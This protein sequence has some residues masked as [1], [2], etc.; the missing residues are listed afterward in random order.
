VTI[1]SPQSPKKKT[2][3]EIEGGKEP[4][5][6]ESQGASYKPEEIAFTL[7]LTDLGS[8]EVPLLRKGA[9]GYEGRKLRKFH[10]RAEEK[11]TQRDR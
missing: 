10:T 3:L 9:E 6:K 1:N 4:S 5:K 2:P 8:I 7:T 11:K